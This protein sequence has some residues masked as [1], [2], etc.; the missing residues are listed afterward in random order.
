MKSNFF[1]SF[2]LLA[3]LVALNLQ[4]H[5]QT[6]PFT[7]NFSCDVVVGFELRGP[8]PS[9]DVCDAGSITIPANSTVMYTVGAACSGASVEGCIYVVTIGGA[10]VSYNH[11]SWNICCTILPILTGPDP[12]SCGNTGLFNVNY[13]YPGGWTINP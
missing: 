11:C 4:T 13:S 2:M 6:V 12:S 1:K 3:F 5:A 10:S 8:N 9:C 7:N